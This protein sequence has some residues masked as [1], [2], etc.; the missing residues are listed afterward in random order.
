MNNP[1]QHLNELNQART[2]VL[3]ALSAEARERACCRGLVLDELCDRRTRLNARL[4]DID[5]L[6]GIMAETCAQPARCSS[7]SPTQWLQKARQ[8]LE[9]PWI[10]QTRNRRLRHGEY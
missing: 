8:F 1:T 7:G 4:K 9:R 3:V 2:V 5:H 6:I 10:S